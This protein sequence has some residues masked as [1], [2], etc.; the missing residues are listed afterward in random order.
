MNMIQTIMSIFVDIEQPPKWTPIPSSKYIFHVEVAKEKSS[1]WNPYLDHWHLLLFSGSY[2]LTWVVPIVFHSEAFLA[3]W[4]P[5]YSSKQH[6]TEVGREWKCIGFTS[7]KKTCVPLWPQGGTMVT[8]NTQPS[9][10]ITITRGVYIMVAINSCYY[11][12]YGISKRPTYHPS[13]WWKK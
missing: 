12:H 10:R 4:F 7:W 1:P 13:I 6:P 3:M 8:K 11:Y 9:H 5:S 2:V